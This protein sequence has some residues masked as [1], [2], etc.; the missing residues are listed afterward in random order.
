MTVATATKP[1]STD[2]IAQEYRYSVWE[3]KNMASIF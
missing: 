3:T 1:T 2:A